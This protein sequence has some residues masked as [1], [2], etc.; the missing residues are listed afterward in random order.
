VGSS[1]WIFGFEKEGRWSVTKKVLKV[2]D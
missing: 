2:R 1:L